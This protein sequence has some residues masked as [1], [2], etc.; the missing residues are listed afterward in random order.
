MRDGKGYVRKD[1]T[2]S[3]LYMMYV[4]DHKTPSEI[5]EHYACST[6]CIS[7]RIH[8]YGFSNQHRKKREIPKDV[9]EELAKSMTV[10]EI[11]KRTG[12][13]RTTIYSKL[14]RNG[15]GYVRV[16]EKKRK[17]DHSQDERLFELYNDGL[18][19]REISVITGISKSTVARRIKQMSNTPEEDEITDK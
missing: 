16:Y 6:S 14:K 13:P 2:K 18:T 17:S 10:P 1:I 4:L 5:A 8:S 7:N 3:E 12:I 19:V 9:L 15:I 11:S